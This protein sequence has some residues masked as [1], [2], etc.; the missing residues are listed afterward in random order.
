MDRYRTSD[1][2]QPDAANETIDE[3]MGAIRQMMADEARENAAPV[4]DRSDKTDEIEDSAQDTPPRRR[5]ARSTRGVEVLPPL[6]ETPGGAAAA[7][8]AA[9]APKGRA[10]GA[11]LFARIRERIGRFEPT[12]KQGVFLIFLAVMIWRPWLIPGLLF[13][14]FWLGLIAYFTLGP[15]RVSELV[16]AGWE[17]FSRR[18]PERAGR[19]LARVQHGADRMD[20]WLARL[21]ERWTDGIYLPDLGRSTVN[22]NPVEERDDPF[23]KLAAEREALMGGGPVRP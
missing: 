12:K 6:E 1:K 15:E 2:T 19:I 18:F 4:S 3:T 21:P 10:I 13:L 8:H 14:T 16:Q 9:P 5:R 22:E 17:R 20:G 7:A 23:E 11:G